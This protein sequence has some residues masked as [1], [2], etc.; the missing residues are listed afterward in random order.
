MAKIILSDENIVG[1]IK[2]IPLKRR[3][4]FLI[5]FVTGLNL[6]VV[7]HVLD[8]KIET[9]E[10]GGYR[11]I[12]GERPVARKT[13]YSVQ[14]RPNEFNLLC[15]VAAS[16]PANAVRRLKHTTIA[17][18][19]TCKRCKVLLEK[20]SWNTMWDKT[21]TDQPCNKPEPVEAPPLCSEITRFGKDHTYKSN[22]YEDK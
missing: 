10:R 22:R 12:L 13:H 2:K 20:L 18:E 6:D 4:D 9:I 11:I 21:A 19:V 14:T 16:L 3:Q 1:M 7:Y 5:E 15:P 8:K 17:A